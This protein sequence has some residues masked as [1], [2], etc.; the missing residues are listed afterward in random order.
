MGHTS[1]AMPYLAQSMARRVARPIL[2]LVLDKVSII[3]SK[4]SRATAASV[5]PLRDPAGALCTE[6]TLL[7]SISSASSLEDLVRS[8]FDLDTV[9][10]WGD[11]T[12]EEKLNFATL[13]GYCF[14][15]KFSG[16]CG[17]STATVELGEALFASSVRD[18][19]DESSLVS[20][21]FNF[22]V[23]CKV[24]FVP[25]IRFARTKSD[26][27]ASGECDLTPNAFF[28]FFPPF[29]DSPDLKSSAPSLLFEP[30]TS[31][32]DL[33]P[34]VNAFCPLSSC[35][36]SLTLLTSLESDISPF[37]HDKLSKLDV[38]ASFFSS[39]PLDV[40]LFITVD[41]A[42]DELSFLQPNT[43]GFSS[44]SPPSPHLCVQR[45]N[46]EPAVPI[47]FMAL[48]SFDTTLPA[49]S[50]KSS[51][52]PSSDGTSEPTSESSVS[53]RKPL[54]FCFSD[55]SNAAQISFT[56]WA[57]GNK[58]SVK[59]EHKRWALCKKMNCKPIDLMNR[60]KQEGNKEESIR[61]ITKSDY[62]GT[63]SHLGGPC[64]EALDLG[65]HKIAETQVPIGLGLV[66]SAS[67]RRSHDN[68]DA[69]E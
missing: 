3:P 29:D 62:S 48:S 17:K 27:R 9:T 60:S 11:F 20:K 57:K 67:T 53:S 31:C 16:L 37:R 69:G 55:S 65:K 7:S 68:V 15:S 45:S 26:L 44:W 30:V 12:G 43:D 39:G 18:R 6:P 4:A 13:D 46:L 5:P 63:K 35:L 52:V 42:G 36:R 2:S 1:L 40:L 34:F 56:A 21:C 49:A 54:A 51:T 47:Q 33:F 14:E 58:S 41:R 38:L 24:S 23:V 8:A 28:P 22:F 50:F 59:E 25:T 10:N 66:R 64:W 19:K 61:V 32:F